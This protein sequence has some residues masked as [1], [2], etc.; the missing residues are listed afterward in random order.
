MFSFRLTLPALLLVVAATGCT[1][2]HARTE[3]AIPELTPPP[4]PPRLVQRYPEEPELAAEPPV[5]EATA[6]TIPP[7][8]PQRPPTPKPTEPSAPPKPEPAKTEP[9]RPAGQPPS[10]TL[11]PSPGNETTAA[12]IRGLIGRASR[13]LGRVNYTALDQDGKTQYD[14]AKRFVQQAEQELRAGNLVF[15]GKLADKAATMAAV[16]VR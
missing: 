12:S 3:P 9:E 6:T 1:K 10:L 11:K 16:L 5:T 13:D 7:R 2:V 15:A 8:S 4:P 14:T